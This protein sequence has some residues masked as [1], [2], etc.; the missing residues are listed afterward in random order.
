[1][2]VDNK[3]DKVQ[4]T[5]DQNIQ[6]LMIHTETSS[7]DERTW[8][9]GFPSTQPKA[10]QDQTEETGVGVWPYIKCWLEQRPHST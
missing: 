10:R 1:M 6:N 2:A 7:I 3:N 9:L 8:Y 4:N 5:I